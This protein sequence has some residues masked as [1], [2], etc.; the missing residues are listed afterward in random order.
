MTKLP[1]GITTISGQLPQSRMSSP[2]IDSLVITSGA[3]GRISSE[4]VAV[5][6]SAAL[7]CA[8]AVRI[9]KIIEISIHKNR[10]NSLIQFVIQ[11]I[12]AWRILFGFGT[13]H[14]I[15]LG[16]RLMSLR[17]AEE[18]A[19]CRLNFGTAGC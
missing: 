5:P 9:K 2:G 7:G 15:L 1:P 13:M 18:E 14:F 11:Q 3:K 17:E 6:G 10:C 4:L 12:N 8:D 16:S 19:L